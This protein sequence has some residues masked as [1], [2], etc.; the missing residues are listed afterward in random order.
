M[1]IILFLIVLWSTTPID[2]EKKEV[3]EF[4]SMIECRQIQVLIKEAGKLTPLIL[5][6]EAG[7]KGLVI[8]SLCEEEV[9]AT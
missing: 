9:Q 6:N 5:T 8:G 1:K 3:K 7:V 4:T 2:V